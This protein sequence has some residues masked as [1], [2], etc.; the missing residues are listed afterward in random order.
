MGQKEGSKKSGVLAFRQVG[1]KCR[2]GTSRR[3]LALKSGL[4]RW[5]GPLER[6]DS[7]Q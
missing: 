2:E 1:V 7:A 5:A 3:E 4:E 6:E